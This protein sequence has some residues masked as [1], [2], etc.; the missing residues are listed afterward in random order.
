MS[1]TKEQTQHLYHKLL[2]MQKELSGE[3]KETESMT[4]EVG[5]F[6]M[7]LTTTWQI[8]ERSSQTG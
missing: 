8:T 1:L 3:K 6:Q 4:E 2:D 5:S 7:G